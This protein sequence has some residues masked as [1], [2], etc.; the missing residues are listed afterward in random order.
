VFLHYLAKQ[1]NTKL[2]TRS[3]FTKSVMVSVAVSKMGVVGFFFVEPGVKVNIK[4]YRDAFYRSKCYLLSDTW[5]TILSFSKTAH[6]RIGRVI[7]SNSC[8][9]KYVISLLQS[10]GPQHYR[11]ELN[12]TDYKIWGVMQQRV[13]TICRSTMSTNSSSNCL[14]FGVVCSTVLSTLLSASGESICRRVFA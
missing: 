4:Y 7:Q 14:T 12:P 13:C 10:Y 2:R 5:V 1:K 3:T 11:P 9:V 6:L 8:S